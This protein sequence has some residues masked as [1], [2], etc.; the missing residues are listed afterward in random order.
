MT[1]TNGNVYQI[2]ATQ[3]I[4]N[5]QTGL[6][7]LEPQANLPVTGEPNLLVT[8]GATGETGRPLL[9]AAFDPIND[10]VLCVV[11][12]L[13]R[14]TARNETYTAAAKITRTDA[15]NYTVDRVYG[16]NPFT[17]TG[18][19][20]TPP[21]IDRDDYLFNPD[22][23]HLREIEVDAFGNVYVIS[24]HAIDDNDWILIY[25]PFG[26]ERC[27]SFVGASFTRCD[28]I[29]GVQLH[30][31]SAM[32]VSDDALYV[33]SSVETLPDAQS[34][35]YRFDI[36]RGA[37]N[38]VL[39]LVSNG[40]IEIDHPVGQQLA[41]VGQPCP[42]IGGIT[43]I[44]QNPA[45]GDLYVLG[46]SAPQP[47]DSFL[48]TDPI[49]N[50]S[51]SGQLLA[52]PT[53]VVV[54][55][56]TNG[57]VSASAIGCAVTSNALSLPVSAV[58]VGGGVPGDCDQDGDMDLADYPC[59]EPCVSGP[60]VPASPGCEPFDLNGDTHVDLI[61]FGL[62]I[63][64]V[65]PGSPGDCDQDGDVDLA[66]YPC[67]EPCVSGPVNPASPACAPFDFDQDNDVD[68]LDFQILV[69]MAPN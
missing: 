23:Q 65:P 63:A 35:L 26:A 27:L 50:N 54:D 61:D 69:G 58:F 45:N 47:D 46:F 18:V 52:T 25:D 22:F 9:D 62:F 37:G 2:H 30:S 60:V 34:R 33:A 56:S 59:F 14:D 28:A 66:D 42:Q 40:F 48:V 38:E 20:I 39:D 67:F 6:T 7:F 24:A 17:D 36:Q 57:P 44:T 51:Q 64:Q 21:N 12:V 10:A 5:L 4:V 16:T 53:L 1:D 8:V 49:F 19:T 43:S 31:P 68:L 3:G 29:E 11:P 32:F 41:C 13:V 55:L 15:Q